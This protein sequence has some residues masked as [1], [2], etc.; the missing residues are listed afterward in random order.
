L[1]DEASSKNRSTDHQ[2]TMTATKGLVIE[3]PADRR[4]VIDGKNSDHAIDVP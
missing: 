2:Q 1:H 3:I 4:T